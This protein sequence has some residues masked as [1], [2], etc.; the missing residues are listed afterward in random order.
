M[1]PPIH[2]QGSYG[3]GDL[4]DKKEARQAGIAAVHQLLFYRKQPWKAEETLVERGMSGRGCLL[5]GE[6]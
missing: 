1:S 2:V 3:L 6:L 4:R 5:L